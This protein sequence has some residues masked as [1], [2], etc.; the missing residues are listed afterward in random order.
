M[1]DAPLQERYAAL[2]AD[3]FDAWGAAVELRLTERTAREFEREFGPQALLAAIDA[4]TKA[5]GDRPARKLMLQ[6]ARA[7]R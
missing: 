3:G 7:L 2:R 4:A 5:M 6:A 1:T